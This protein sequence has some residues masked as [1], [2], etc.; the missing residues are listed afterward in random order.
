VVLV[1]A[2]H[3]RMLDS[4]LE[5]FDIRP[6]YDLNIMQ[7]NQSLADVTVKTLRGVESVL[8]QEKPEMVVVQGDT[9]S[10]L[11][12]A[13]AAFYGRIPVGHVEAGLRTRDKYAPYPEEM[14]RRLV[15]SMADLHFA[16]TAWAK[17][18]LLREG[19]P[20]RAIRVT[21]NTVIDALKLVLKNQE[22]RTVP[23]PGAL[24]CAP[25]LAQDFPA[26]HKL[27]LVTA[28]RRESFGPPLI[29]I[30]RALRAI[31]R[32]NSDVELVYP[33]HPNPNVQAP[34]NR[35]LGGQWRIHLIEP[36]EYSTFALLLERSYLVLTD[37]GGIQEE[38]PALGKPVLVLRDK[39]ERPEALRAG[40][41]KLVGTDVTR[42]VSAT[43]RLLRSPATYRKM[44]RAANPFGDG[45]AAKRILT[46][47]R[48]FLPCARSGI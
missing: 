13:L 18:N 20:R 39:T 23:R 24:P 25:G 9:T 2:Q 17:E 34:V 43:E 35:L 10:A 36:V 5:L 28:H 14:N 40:T 41:A 45:K 46:A 31:V 47:L 22:S 32:R 15:S 33:V 16:P 37:S 42:I 7:Q 38:A 4:T 1:T 21:G 44:A 27:I 12:A 30:C 3:R 26:G 19:V 29:R 11:A 48:R 6:D 8:A